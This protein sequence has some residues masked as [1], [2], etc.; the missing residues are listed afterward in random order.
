MI[1]PIQQGLKQFALTFEAPGKGPFLVFEG[2]DWRGDM[3]KQIY[4]EGRRVMVG[5]TSEDSIARLREHLRG[6]GHEV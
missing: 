6:H 2:F 1:A 3:T 4:V 5:S